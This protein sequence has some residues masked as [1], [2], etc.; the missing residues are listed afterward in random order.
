MALFLHNHG[1]FGA[2]APGEKGYLEK[3]PYDYREV[4]HVIL[5]F[6]AAF[7]RF[8]T[9]TITP[10]LVILYAAL[11]DYFGDVK[12]LKATSEATGKKLLHDWALIWYVGIHLDAAIQAR[13]G[14]EGQNA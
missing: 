2:V 8:D 5:T 12:N 14:T 11:K 13:L 9:T 3:S 1:A 7:H 10:R 4:H 6:V